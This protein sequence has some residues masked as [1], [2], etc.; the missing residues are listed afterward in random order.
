MKLTEI[1]TAAGR[2]KPRKRV[3]RGIGSG[4]GKTCG[5]GHKGRGARAGAGQRLGYEGGQTPVFSR[6]PKRGFSNV[7]F[8]R[9]P[10]VVNVSALDR[11]EDGTRVDAV[12]LA[13]AKLIADAKRPVKVLGNGELSK[14]LTVVAAAFSAAAAEKITKAGGT[15]EQVE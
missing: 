8:R 5:R 2:K 11:F 3:G 13:A 15:A 4:H 7:Q 14:K 10:Q 12:A 6:M 9:P 1:L